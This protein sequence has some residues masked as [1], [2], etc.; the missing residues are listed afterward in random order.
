MMTEDSLRIVL[1]RLRMGG[2]WARAGLC[3]FA[4]ESAHESVATIVGICWRCRVQILAQVTVVT[5]RV[6]PCVSVRVTV[7]VF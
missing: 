7:M 6:S 3:A 5:R 4:R 2:L 1:A